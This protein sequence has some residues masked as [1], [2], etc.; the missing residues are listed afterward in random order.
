MSVSILKISLIG[1]REIGQGSGA[2]PIARMDNADVF[3]HEKAS[4][5]SNLD[6]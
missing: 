5:G 2:M 4:R 3:G 1:L 6:F